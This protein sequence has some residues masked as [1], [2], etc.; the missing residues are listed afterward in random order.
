V[1]MFFDSD[2]RRIQHDQALCVTIS[3]AASRFAGCGAETSQ[4]TL[5]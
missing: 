1:H 3:T 4:R 5:T 2:G